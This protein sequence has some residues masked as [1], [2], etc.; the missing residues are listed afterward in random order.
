MLLYYFSTKSGSVINF[1]LIVVLVSGI[2]NWNCDK[3]AKRV[4]SQKQTSLKKKI[5]PNVQKQNTIL[6]SIVPHVILLIPLPTSLF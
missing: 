4:S 2:S 5:V 1:N 3:I 6:C